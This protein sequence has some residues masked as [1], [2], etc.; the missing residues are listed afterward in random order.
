[1]QVVSPHAVAAANRTT[2]DL[3]ALS[4]ISDIIEDM[5]NGRMVILV[6]DEDR[7]N[8]GDLVLPAQ[9]ITP[10][11]INFMA[12]H[13][14]GLICLAMEKEQ[15]ERL[16]LP[17][18]AARNN[19]PLSTAFTVSIEAKTGV[20]T[21]IS[22]PD[23]AR[24]IQ[25]AIDPGASAGDIVT[26]GHVFPL[27]AVPGGT[28]VRTGHTE[29]SVD[30]ARMAGLIPAGVICEI[31]KEDGEMARLPD[32][33]SFAQL[34][35]MKIGTIADLVAFRLHHESHVKKMDTTQITSKFGGTFTQHKY[36]DRLNNRSIDVLIKGDISKTEPTLVRVHTLDAQA[37]IFG[38]GESKLQQAMEYMADHGHGVVVCMPPMVSAD[39]DSKTILR[40]YGIGAQILRDLG[41]QRMVLLTSSAKHV[42]GL[43]GFGIEIIEQRSLD[44][45][46]P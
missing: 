42:A 12:T 2:E 9:M 10:A 8:E 14:R 25:V 19:A 20:T 6:D 39:S 35:G 5:R 4:S 13:G 41:V 33:V 17:P 30:L 28:L 31:M 16:G 32:L 7:E 15:V 29:A 24:T 44:A 38:I 34:H 40:H 36:L 3:S 26:P 21:G 22:A 43:H 18:M 23:R 11:A 37:D 45:S 27:Q 46:Q 1:M